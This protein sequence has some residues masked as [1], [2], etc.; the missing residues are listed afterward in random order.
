M[1]QY[2]M[3]KKDRLIKDEPVWAQL[4]VYSVD[5]REF[6]RLGM[7]VQQLDQAVWKKHREHI[8]LSP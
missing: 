8:V 4:L 6:K 5:S 2:I 7:C 1:E 3:K